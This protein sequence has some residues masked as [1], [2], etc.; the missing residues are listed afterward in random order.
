MTESKKRQPSDKRRDDGGDEQDSSVAAGTDQDPDAP[1]DPGADPLPGEEL[2]TPP[3]PDRKPDPAT[4]PGPH[5]G[6]PY[7]DEAPAFGQ[8]GMT[9]E[10]SLAMNEARLQR[11]R[12][13]AGSEDNL[14]LQMRSNEAIVRAWHQ[15]HLP[16]IITGR[17]GPEPEP[18]SEGAI[19]R[20]NLRHEM[21]RRGLFTAGSS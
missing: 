15:L 14:P 6:T 9:R 10:E 3:F 18:E 13:L 7:Q 1:R 20:E 2:I 5:A 19:M 4:Q 17:D 11:E 21:N 12:I 16:G 8:R